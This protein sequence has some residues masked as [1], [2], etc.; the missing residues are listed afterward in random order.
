MKRANLPTYDALMNP[1]IQALKSLGDLARSRNLKPKLPKSSDYWMSNWKSHTIQRR[2]AKQNSATDWP[3]R[4]LTSSALGLSRTRPAVS[5]R[6]RLQGTNS[7]ALKRRKLSATHGSN[8][9]LRPVEL[10]R[11]NLTIYWR[12]QFPGE[13]S[14]CRLC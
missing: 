8:S 7:T 3:G 14:Y 1:L 10:R 9:G 5:G 6:C 13:M 11:Q 2:E 4:E 12:L